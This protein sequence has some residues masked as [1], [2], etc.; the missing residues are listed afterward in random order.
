MV[1]SEDLLL[2]A[3]GHWVPTQSPRIASLDVLR[4]CAAAAV[5]LHHHGQYYEVLFPGRTPLDFDMGPGHFG[6][7]LF[8]IISGFVILM[9]IERKNTIRDFAISRVTRLMPASLAALL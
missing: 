2:E 8:F 5:M 9:T 1:I 4:G 6:V 7:E 3:R